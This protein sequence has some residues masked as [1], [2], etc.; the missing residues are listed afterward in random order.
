LIGKMIF[1][2]LTVVFGAV[3]LMKLLPYD[4]AYYVCFYGFGD[5]GKCQRLL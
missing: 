2:V 1:S 3:G 5:A 4:V